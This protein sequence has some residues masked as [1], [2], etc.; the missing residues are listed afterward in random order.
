[1][2]YSRFLI[3]VESYFIEG[4]NFTLFWGLIFS[5]GGLIFSIGGLIFSMR[6]LIFSVRGLIFL[7]GRGLILFYLISK[8]NAIETA[9]VSL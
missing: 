1:M 5:I 6:G 8:I 3:I 2:R 9:Q 4:S 7:V